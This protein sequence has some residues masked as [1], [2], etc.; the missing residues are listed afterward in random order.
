MLV[1]VFIETHRSL[2]EYMAA[3]GKHIP[4]FVHQVCVINPYRMLYAAGRFSLSCMIVRVRSCH[5]QSGIRPAIFKFSEEDFI[6]HPSYQPHP[7][8]CFNLFSFLM[9]P[10]NGQEQ[11]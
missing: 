10:N 5:A 1:G 11:M 8:C 2:H 6:D 9:L 7:V 4:V 3:G